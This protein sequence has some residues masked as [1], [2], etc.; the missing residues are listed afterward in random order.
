MSYQISIAGSII[1]KL[2]FEDYNFRIGISREILERYDKSHKDFLAL[3]DFANLHT[4]ISDLNIQL[5]MYQVE[6]IIKGSNY[7]INNN[8]N[9]REKYLRCHKTLEVL[10]RYGNSYWK[11]LDL[12]IGE[13]PISKKQSKGFTLKSEDLD[14]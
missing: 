6:N 2:N 5:T 12:K 11:T 7:F 10:S 8:P 4:N 13:K 1:E 3:L 14:L 9:I